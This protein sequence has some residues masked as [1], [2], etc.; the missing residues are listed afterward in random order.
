MRRWLWWRKGDGME[1]GFE[2]RYGVQRLI[3]DEERSAAILELLDLDDAADLRGVTGAGR[4]YRYRLGGYPH[5]QEQLKVDLEQSFLHY[6]MLAARPA[7]DHV[8]S[9]RRY[10]YGPVD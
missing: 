3:R 7:E 1:A 6:R 5:K 4:G 8:V 2:E 10:R 9:L